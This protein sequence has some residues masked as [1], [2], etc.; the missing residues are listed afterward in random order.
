MH[1]KSHD[2]PSH[3]ACVAPVGT[4]QG[5]HEVPHAFTSITDG[6]KPL[7]A[8]CAIGHEPPHAAVASMHA[9]RHSCLRVAQDPPHEVPSQVAVP[10]A[11]V[12][13]GVHDVPSQV[14][15][16]APVGTGQDRQPAPQAFTSISENRE[17]YVEYLL[18]RLAPP[19]AFV[20]EAERARTGA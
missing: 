3:V 12:S 2:V 1:W 9:P 15:C 7:Q 19:R 17:A 16:K 10:S 6:H 11:G 20:E 13:H 8:C 4:G 18:A 5:R 14:A